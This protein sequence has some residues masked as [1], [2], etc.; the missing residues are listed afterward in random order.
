MGKVGETFLNTAVY[1]RTLSRWAAVAREATTAKP[2]VLRRQ[3]VQAERLRGYLDRIG[4]IAD[5]RLARPVEGS[6]SFPRPHNSDW[7][8]RPDLWRSKIAPCGIAQAPSR[9]PMGNEVTLFHD[10][11]QPE[12]TLRQI[13]NHHADDL[14]AYG[15]CLDVLNFEG[16][17]A[18]LV[19]DLPQDVIGDLKHHHILTTRIVVEIETPLACY[20]RLNIRNGPNTEQI[21]QRLCTETQEGSVQFDLEYADFNKERI[22]NIWIDVIFKHPKMNRIFLR[23]LT[24]SRH[25]R[26]QL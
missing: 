14:A 3:A 24:F 8:W 12:L 4:R 5:E 7:A 2:D 18:S 26:A 22:E 23:D 21:V 19:I 13:R 6:N 16:T 11:D 10:C 9:T 25:R 20:V 15:V 1:R 17:F